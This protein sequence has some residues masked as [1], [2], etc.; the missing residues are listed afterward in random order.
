MPIESLPMPI[1][2]KLLFDCIAVVLFLASAMGYWRYD[3][4]SKR[5][6]RQDSTARIRIPMAIRVENSLFFWAGM[7][8]IAT[9]SPDWRLRTFFG[10]VAVLGVVL[11]IYRLRSQPI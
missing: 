7:V 4:E 2:V 11:T 6:L 10:S 9:T 8:C 1:A 3:R 5:N